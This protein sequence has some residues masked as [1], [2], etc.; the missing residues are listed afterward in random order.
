MSDKDTMQPVTIC[1]DELYAQVWAT[2][3]SQ[4]AQHY[5]ISGKGLAKIC[6][7]LDVPYPPRGY[8]ARKTAGQKV[9]QKPLPATKPDKP[10]QVTITPS[11]PVPPPPKLSREL[12]DALAAARGLTAGLS[13]PKKLQRPHPVIAGWIKER[14]DRREEA[15]RWH[16]GGPLPADFAPIERRR[17]RILSALFI[18]VE[19]HGYA[20]KLDDRGRIF[21]EINREPVFLTLKEKYRQVRRPLTDEEKKRD[22]NPKRPWKQETQATGLL[23]F[24]I[25]SRLDPALVHSFIDNPDAPLESQLPEIAAQFIAAAPLLQERRRQ[26]EAAEQRR[27]GEELR[28][29]EERQNAQKEQNQLRAL[30]DLAARWK[31]TQIAREFLGALKV[32]PDDIEPAIDGR[33]VEEWM[34]WARDRLNAH[35]PLQTGASAVFRTIASVDQW[36]YRDGWHDS[37]V[38]G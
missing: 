8:W 15:R 2:P 36:T 14:S 3:I 20:A 33:T 34:T 10:A 23:Q 38:S 6:D 11:L 21:L 29:Y 35:D 16:G 1:R 7:R 9:A 5:G 26:Y 12:E 25:E 30:L 32:H 37:H 4:L 27:R 19:K 24:V 18:A 22:F 13:V 28:R 31:E 17:H